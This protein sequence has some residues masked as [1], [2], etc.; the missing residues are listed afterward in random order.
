MVHME[1]KLLRLVTNWWLINEGYRTNSV[2]IQTLRHGNDKILAKS[3]TQN[4]S[5]VTLRG[6]DQMDFGIVL[7]FS[8]SGLLQ[9]LY[10]C[11][12][13]TAVTLYPDQFWLSATTVTFNNPASMC[14]GPNGILLILNNTSDKKKSSLLS[15]RLHNPVEAK[16]ILQI[17]DQLSDMTYYDGIIFLTGNS[18]DQNI[19]FEGKVVRNINSLRKQELF[20][21]AIDLNLVSPTSD[22][23]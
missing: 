16:V 23:S 13:T 2:I 18:D 12:N 4:I 9:L 10:R 11:E 8:N 14:I 3:L 1:K 7:E 21:L 5:D 17:N 20:Q 22:Q 6:R 19:D 15:L